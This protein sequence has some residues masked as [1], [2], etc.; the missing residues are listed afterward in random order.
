MSVT[1][2]SY[3][4]TAAERTEPA[5]ICSKDLLERRAKA[6]KQSLEYYY[7]HREKIN[8]RRRDANRAW[9]NRWRKQNPELAKKRK[10]EW[11][12]KHPESFRTWYRKN[13]ASHVKTVMAWQRN[14]PEKVRQY[15]VKSKPLITERNRIYVETL[16]EPYVRAKLARDTRI[17][18]QAW[19]KPLV[20]LKRAELKLKRLCQNL[21]TS[22]NSAT[23]S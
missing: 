6:S 14:H 22:T 20:E 18:S 7:R 21:K 19:P 3:L 10:R 11:Y 17:P 9:M 4:H 15:R 1:P 23:N 2:H 8:A 12:A 16:A 5:A 13:Y